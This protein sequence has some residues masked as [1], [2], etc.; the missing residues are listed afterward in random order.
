ML[1]EL[2]PLQIRYSGLC[3]FAML[4]TG[5]TLWRSQ[6]L[7]G[8]HALDVIARIIPYGV[9]GVVFGGRLVHCF[10]YEPGHYL[11]NPLHV[12][13]LRRSGLASHGSVLGLLTG[14]WLYSRR[15]GYALLEVVDRLAY[16]LMPAGAFVRLG[17]FMN[18]EIVGTEWI[19]PLA[20]RFERYAQQSQ[21]LW[22][23]SHAALAWAVQPLPRHPV[24]LYEGAGMMAIFGVVWLVDRRLGEK[25]PLGLISGLVLCLY[26]SFRLGLEQL[27][28]VQ[29]FARLVPE[30][31]AQVIHVVPTAD[32]TMGQWLSLPGVVAGI[33][34]ISYA[35][36]T[37]RAAAV[38]APTDPP[39]EPSAAR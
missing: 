3:F 1:L 9:L 21:I 20:V 10:F 6:M 28:E 5:Y 29:R 37:R 23:R 8:G 25:R 32:L 4:L 16:A 15:Y 39:A 31:V 34:L 18:S 12:L 26:F 22:E 13:D 27:K 19:G 38:A 30:P 24:Q 7:R 33:A 11:A 2:G 17:N 14:L 36:W 35:L